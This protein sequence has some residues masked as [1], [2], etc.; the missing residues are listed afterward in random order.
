M[1]IEPVV[2][3]IE[4][5]YSEQLNVIRVDIQSSAGRELASAYDFQFTPTF[6]FFDEDGQ[7]VWRQV[8]SLDSDRVRVTLK[9]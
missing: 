7:E 9:P 4:E 8:G 2:N 5:N 6:I 3:R 1:R